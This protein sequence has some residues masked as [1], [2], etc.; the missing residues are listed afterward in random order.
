MQRH[1]IVPA[2]SLLVIVARR[3]GALASLGHNHVIASHDLSGY[4]DLAEP[5]A[6][7]AFVLRLPLDTLTVDEPV[8][9]AGRGAQFEGEVPDSAREGTRRNM[10]GGDLLDVAHHPQITIR[11]LALSGGPQNFAVRVELTVRA[12]PATIVVP[13]RLEPAPAGTLRVSARFPVTQ[14]ALGL[15]PFSAMLGALRVEDALEVELD[16]TARRAP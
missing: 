2:E 14:S 7:S 5:P 11:G 9:R 12:K 10:L 16:L 1:R 4:I 15:T 13:V 8:L 3:G 6:A